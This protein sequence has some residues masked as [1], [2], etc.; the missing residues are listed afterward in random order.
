MHLEPSRGRDRRIKLDVTD[1][2]NKVLVHLSP[3]LYFYKQRGREITIRFLNANDESEATITPEDIPEF[4]TKTFKIQT[5][6]SETF[7]FDLSYA[8]LQGEARLNAFHCADMRTVCSFAEKDL[9]LSM[10]QGYSG[11]F[12][13]ESEYLRQRVN[14]DRNDFDI[15]PVR[16]DF[17][18]PIS[19]EII[20]RHLKGELKEIIAAE[21]PYTEGR[22]RDK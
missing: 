6:Q 13:L 3:I 11:I 16:T 17:F 1:V 19:W 21:L 22:N 7:D 14:N 4:R 10:P 15:Y 20:N 2:R 12:L 8:I 9:K 5:A 18:V